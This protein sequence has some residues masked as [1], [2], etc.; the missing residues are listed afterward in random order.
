D[1]EVGVRAGVEPINV[2]TTRGAIIDAEFVP[3]KYRG[4]DRFE[5]RK[6][7]IADLADLAEENPTRGLS[8]IEDKKIMVPHDEKSKLVVIEPCLTGRWWVKADVLA[9][10]ALASVREGRTR[11]V[12]QQYENTYFA[13]LEN[14]KP[15]CISR[16][17]WWGHQIPA[18]YGPDNE[19][20]VAYDEAEA[21]AA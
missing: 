17:L 1:F 4:L 7:I 15:W 10:P 12:P 21:R 14:I 20:F 13:W 19:A 11:F 6:A 2:F 5:A 18:W 16:Q 9:Q 3:A 8:H